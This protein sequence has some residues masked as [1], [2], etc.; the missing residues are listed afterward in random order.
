M[1]QTRKLH[2]GLSL[3]YVGVTLVLCA[4]PP[5]HYLVIDRSRC[6]EGEPEILVASGDLGYSP[7][8]APPH[9]EPYKSQ[10]YPDIE[11]DR[12]AL[13]YEIACWSVLM[14]VAIN[15]RKVV[16]RAVPRRPD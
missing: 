15:W 2:V 9:K 6:W 16:H 10:I 12:G 5:W 11:I 4:I 14:G 3:L 7:F 1:T 13:L 8:F